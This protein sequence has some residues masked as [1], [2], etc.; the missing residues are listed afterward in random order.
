VVFYDD[1]VVLG[2]AVIEKPLTGTSPQAEMALE[3]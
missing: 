3:T 1:D 2:G